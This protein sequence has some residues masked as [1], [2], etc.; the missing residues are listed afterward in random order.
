[1]TATNANRDINSRRA[2][3]FSQLSVIMDLSWL[4]RKDYRIVN[5]IEELNE[6]IDEMNKYDLISVDTEDTGLM[7]YD[8]P[9]DNPLKDHIVGMSISWKHDQGIYIPFTHT[10]F[11]N[12]NKH[13]A[14]KKLRPILEKKKII[15]HNGLFDG[16]VFYDEGIKLN[17]VHD[18]MILYF[19]LD[20]TVS[21][22]S[23]GLKPLAKH[24]FGYD[25]IELQDIFGETNDY[26][27][28][29]YVEEDLVKAY[30]CADS[31]H[32]LGLFMNSIGM[33]KPSQ[34]K[35]YALDIKVQNH[36]VRTE[37]YGKGV[38][39]ELLKIL[40]DVNRKDMQKLESLIYSYVGNS[41]ATKMG[42]T[43]RGMYR[44]SLTA[45]DA[46]ANVMFSMLDYPMIKTGQ[47]G[48]ATVDKFVLRALDREKTESHDAVFEE[49]IKGDVESEVANANLKWVHDDDKV[50]LEYKKIAK[51]KYKLAYLLIKY[52]KLEKL[53]SSFFDPLLRNN[54]GG[55][56]FTSFSMTRA[57][58]ARIIDPAQT[59]DKSLKRLIIP[60]RAESQ[61]EIDYDHA[62]IEYRTMTGQAGIKSLIL[63]LNNPEADYHRL[64]GSLILGKAPE[65]ITGDERK[66]LKSVNFGI[67]YG[68]GDYGILHNRYGIGLSP[69]EE[70]KL[71][72]E[73]R[74]ILRKWHTGLH[75]ISEMLNRYREKAVT[76]VADEFLPKFLQGRKVG[77]IANELG[78]TRI[79]NL[80][81]LT[82]EKANKIRRMAG[83]YPIQSFAREIF[84]TGYV[85]LSD[86][87]IEEGLMDIR[88]PDP[89]KASGYR[90][91]NKVIINGLIHDECL[92]SV[93]DDVNHEFMLKLIQ[94]NCVA[95]IEGHPTY[96]AGVN[97]INNWYQAKDDNYE[98]P[99]ALLET[100]EGRKD[101]AK[102]IEVDKTTRR[103]YSVEMLAKIKVY[104]DKRIYDEIE[105]VDF[106]V[107]KTGYVNA[108]EF[109]S[110]FK[111][112]FVKPKLIG[113]YPNKRKVD[114]DETR[115]DDET[116]AALETYLSTKFDRVLIQLP[117]GTLRVIEHSEDSI[118]I[119]E[120][121]KE[122]NEWKERESEIEAMLS[123]GESADDVDEIDYGFSKENQEFLTNVFEQLSEK[124]SDT[125][126]LSF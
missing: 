126:T 7:I 77:I 4:A 39:M 33:L 34:Y 84:C 116:L 20:S 71:L 59:L 57:E 114:K 5:T 74:E 106:T 37:Y 101:I 98:C 38:D 119:K 51:K 72:K 60:I 88:V 48:K 45:N 73:I 103:D 122:E 58:T 109:M 21:K 19:N 29:E 69:E 41:Y 95:H 35:P 105:K 96:F 81:N 52:R 46:I 36:L 65:D 63:T 68:M 113:F 82:D 10:K 31:D 25:V 83:N 107:T 102:F 27:L 24:M 44:F 53:R 80:D 100:Y 23:K 97:V 91:E 112:Y 64:G 8:L 123:E 76:P 89:S 93:D 110:K 9:D 75:E 47:S 17:I 78:R 11:E 54:Y 49:L 120:I 85:K 22:G 1:M 50:L 13:K 26:S 2:R 16:K 61:Y 121:A 111:N 117:E 62:Q 92:M 108:I 124:Y 3:T 90:F 30:A 32:T 56:Y 87:C 115:W 42:L 55:R 43:R 79:F 40:S 94:E 6:C 66:D 99:A 14:F 28:F 70:K 118:Q 12:I 67:P 104:L 125:H 86:A 15:T 18:T